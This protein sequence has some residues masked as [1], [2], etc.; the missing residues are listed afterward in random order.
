L[1]EARLNNAKAQVGAAESALE[2]LELKAPFAGQ[3]VDINIVPN[4]QLGQNTWAFVLAD[5]GEWYIETDDLTELEVINIAEGQMVSVIPDA[6][7]ELE[8]PG[9]VVE[10]SN[11]STE[12]GGDVLYQVRIRLNE[13]DPRLRWG[14]TV[15]VHFTP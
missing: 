14:M 10:I 3:I 12:K 1:A 2:R 7:P 13:A 8:L 11:M 4:E 15:E 9:T 5:F 6:L